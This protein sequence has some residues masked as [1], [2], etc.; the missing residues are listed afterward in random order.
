[1]ENQGSL[2]AGNP[3]GSKE[4]LAAAKGSK[5]DLTAASHHGSLRN[6]A[7]KVVVEPAAAQ[8]QVPPT[9]AIVYE[10]TYIMKPEKKSQPAKKIVEDLL[11]ITLAKV[12][13]DPDKVQDLSLKISNDAMAALKSWTP[14]N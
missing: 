4:N 6:L 2:K 11:A 12:K 3:R 1:M 13:Y 7:P 10:N 9:N 14:V 8:P 5:Q